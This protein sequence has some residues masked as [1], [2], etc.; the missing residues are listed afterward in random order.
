VVEWAV[1]GRMLELHGGQLAT[2]EE[3]SGSTTCVLTLPLADQD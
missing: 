2:N 1:A 3:R